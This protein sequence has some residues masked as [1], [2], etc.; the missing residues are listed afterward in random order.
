MNIKKDKDL[1]SVDSQSDHSEVKAKHKNRSKDKAGSGK[2]RN[3]KDS[4]VPSNDEFSKRPKTDGSQDQHAKLANI[5]ANAELVKQ[6]QALLKEYNKLKTI[7]EEERMTQQSHLYIRRIAHDKNKQLAHMFKY[8]LLQYLCNSAKIM[9]LNE[10]EIVSWAAWLD[11]IDLVDDQY[12]VEE[13]IL[14]TA[15]F[16]KIS[17]NP[18]VN[19]QDIFEAYFN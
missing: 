16:V 19:L 10:F 12:T 5:S 15:F 4:D 1:I 11:N 3:R 18:K 9:L 6:N 14:F 17:L 7:Y 13:K 2:K 8:P